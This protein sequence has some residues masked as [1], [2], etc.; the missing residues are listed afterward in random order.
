MAA[1]SDRDPVHL[2]VGRPIGAV[3]AHVGARRGRASTT[4]ILRETDRSTVEVAVVVAEGIGVLVDPA[5]AHAHPEKVLG[6]EPTVVVI[7]AVVVAETPRR[8]I[9]WRVGPSG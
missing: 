6:V 8:A 7:A 1:G 2:L 3:I 9:S 4:A 5:V